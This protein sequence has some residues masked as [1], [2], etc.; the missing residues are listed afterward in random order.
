MLHISSLFLSFASN[1]P[2]PPL[3]QHYA[4]SFVE[5]LSSRIVEASMVQSRTIVPASMYRP[6]RT[7]LD[8]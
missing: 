7:T 8:M 4:K 5:G 1:P 2:P 6:T 3:G